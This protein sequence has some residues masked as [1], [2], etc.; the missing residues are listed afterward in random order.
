V[1]GVAVWVGVGALGGIAATA[2]FLVDEAI[3][4]RVTAR[5]PLGTLAVNV[6]GSLVVGVLAGASVH[7]RAYLLTGV[8]VLGS[9]TTFSTWML[10]SRTLAS[11]GRPGALAAL[12]NV[13]A[14]LALGVAAV[15]LGR[16]IAG[17]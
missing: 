8:A 5:L 7:G 9:Y 16:L 14:S 13:A 10:E 4:A 11:E 3:A 17:G 12:V 2:R 15:A 6:S 1:S